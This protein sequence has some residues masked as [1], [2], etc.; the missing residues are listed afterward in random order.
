MGDRVR[1]ERSGWR[2]CVGTWRGVDGV[3]MRVENRNEWRTVALNGAGARSEAWAEGGFT[4]GAGRRVLD[5][6]FK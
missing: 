2:G 5:S 3:C 1:G 6:C 4:T